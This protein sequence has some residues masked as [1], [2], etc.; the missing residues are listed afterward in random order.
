VFTSRIQ[1]NGQRGF[2]HPD[3]F[4]FGQTVYLSRLYAAAQAV[5]GVASVWITVFQRVGDSSS[6]SLDTGKLTLGPLEIARLDHDRM[7]P[8]SGKF[9][10]QVKGGK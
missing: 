1:P 8:D 5:P 10:L 6:N 9:T 4:S 7:R 3:N 2:F